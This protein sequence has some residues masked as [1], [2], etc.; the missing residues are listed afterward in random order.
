MLCLPPLCCYKITLASSL[1]PIPCTQL[2]TFQQ[3][4]F[5]DLLFA[6]YSYRSASSSTLATLSPYSPH[7]LLLPLHFTFST[8]IS[9]DLHPN[10]PR[11]FLLTFVASSSRSSQGDVSIE[12]RI[13]VN[14]SVDIFTE[15]T[16]VK[17]KLTQVKVRKKGR[18]ERKIAFTLSRVRASVDR[19]QFFF[20]RRRC[21]LLR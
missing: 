15:R 11:P 13:Q 18:K 17:V 3:H 21:W 5:I 14:Q 10:L 4:Y 20:T 1:S 19:Q 9:A 7:L 12:H 6:Y 16:K 8:S 2:E